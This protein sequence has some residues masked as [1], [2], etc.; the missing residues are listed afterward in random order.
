MSE[1]AVA[2]AMRLT[3]GAP[4]SV[5]IGALA[6]SYWG[7]LDGPEWRAARSVLQSF[8]LVPCSKQERARFDYEGKVIT[9]A[10][11][12]Q[13]IVSYS[14][15]WTRIALQTLEEMG[16]I[17][18]TRGMI[19][20]GKPTS[21]LLVVVKTKLLELIRFARP[22]S[23]RIDEE[24]RDSF[25]T[26][27]ADI[28]RR[29]R[30]SD[31]AMRAPEAVRVPSKGRGGVHT[32]DLQ[33]RSC[34]SLHAEV[35]A[36]PSTSVGGYPAS[37]V[38]LPAKSLFRSLD[39]DK[40]EAL[41]LFTA[42]ANPVKSL[43]ALSPAR[44]DSFI[45]NYKEDDMGIPIP[46]AHLDRLPDICPHGEADPK[47]CCT[48]IDATRNEIEMINYHARV[49]RTAAY[50][51]AKAKGVFEVSNE[52]IARARAAQIAESE[53]KAAGMKPGLEFAYRV[54][55]RINQLLAEWQARGDAVLW[56]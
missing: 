29:R 11:Q 43:S 14:E 22:R 12:L 40:R 28:L 54:A 44:K 24:R 36:S 46:A 7:V 30:G 37:G 15:K 42:S 13:R 38:N 34:W 17:R 55:E 16:V 25:L 3:A 47:Q 26:R 51:K 9:T 53:A 10:T 6:R 31:G 50:Q 41:D 49:K 18:W 33:T 20:G 5:L 4:T 48:C 27:L 32:N 39:E 23:R 2:P 35:T 19:V 1:E 45:S 56:R 8:T 21:S 52:E